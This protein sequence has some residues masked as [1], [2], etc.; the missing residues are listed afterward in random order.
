MLV[1]NIFH[2]GECSLGDGVK[3]HHLKVIW[4]PCRKSHLL[5]IGGLGGW[6]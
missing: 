6:G 1:N 3:I 4:Y 5:K 2:L